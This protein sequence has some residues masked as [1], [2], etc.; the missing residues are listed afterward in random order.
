[1]RLQVLSAVVKD[2]RVPDATVILQKNGAQSVTKSTDTQGTAQMNTEFDDTDSSLVIIKK[3]G[4]SNL[5]AKCPCAGMTYAISPVLKQLD[6]L[7]VVLNWGAT[8]ADLDEHLVFSDQQIYFKRKTGPDGTDAYLDVDNTEGFGPETIT[9]EK[10]HIEQAYVFAV[11]DYID[12]FDPKTKGLSNSDAKVLVYIGQTLVRTYYVPKNTIGNL[13]AVFRITPEGE[14]QDINTITATNGDGVEVANN[15]STYQNEASAVAAPIIA[16]ADTASA[17]DMNKSGEK[18]YH[19]GNL[20]DAI[21]FYQQAINFDQ[22]YAPAYS[23]LGLAFQKANRTA[24]AIWANRKAIALAKDVQGAT[25]RAGSHY[26]IGKIYEAA[27]QMSDAL[28]QYTAAQQEKA[29]PVYEK[30]IARV[31]EKLRK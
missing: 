30:A 23:N 1:M 7:R 28:G 18:A 8:P 4:Y 5:V 11:H 13:W 26:N 20:D 3:P 24:E 14:F 19:A 10:R 6:G 9:V 31:K 22:N 17:K 12:R 25:T 15:V 21:E 16:V 29:G 27:G 2:Q